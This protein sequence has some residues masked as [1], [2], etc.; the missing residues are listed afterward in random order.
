MFKKNRIARSDLCGD[1]YICIDIILM[2]K[3]KPADNQ[4]IL[5]EKYLARLIVARWAS[6]PTVGANEYGLTIQ[7]KFSV[8]CTAP[9]VG[10]PIF[11]G[12]KA[13]VYVIARRYATNPRETHV[14]PTARTFLNGLGI[15]WSQHP[16]NGLPLQHNKIAIICEF[17]QCDPINGYQSIIKWERATDTIAQHYI[18]QAIS[19]PTRLQIV[20]LEF[21]KECRVKRGKIEVTL[22]SIRDWYVLK[23]LSKN[24]FYREIDLIKHAW[25]I[26]GKT[27]PTEIMATVYDMI[28][29]LNENI[30]RLRIHIVNDRNGNY[31]L[32]NIRLNQRNSHRSLD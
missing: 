32:E 20:G 30:K 29:R 19:A 21:P 13:V 25:D 1:V 10:D 5:H 6:L 2:A 28:R 15:S 14:S 7:L 4:F 3:N 11:C 24:H 17:G 22:R 12:L 27:H 9:Q 23:L 8:L 31:S 26:T 16:N 18:V